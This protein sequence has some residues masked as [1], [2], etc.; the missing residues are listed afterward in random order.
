MNSNYA[1]R[2]L[3]TKQ[4]PRAKKHGFSARMATKNGRAVLKRR[5]A[6]GRKRNGSALLNFRLPKDERLRSLRISPRLCERKAFWRA[7][8]TVFILPSGK[9]F[10]KDSALQLKENQQSRTTQP[11]KRLL[12]EAFRLSKAELN[13]LN[14]KF[15]WVLNDVGVFWA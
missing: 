10:S 3:S 14:I 7:F 11:A 9:R 1:K 13:E 5:R 15:D 12:R 2:N 8:M 4:P 6:K